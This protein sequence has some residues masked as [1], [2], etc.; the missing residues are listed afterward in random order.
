MSDDPARRPRTISRRDA[1]RATGGVLVF[2]GLFILTGCSEDE[3]Q[4]APPGDRLRTAFAGSPTPVPKTPT[5]QGAAA[6]PN[7]SLYDRLGGHE[8]ISRAV[9][10]FLPLVAL[11]RRINAFFANADANRFV[12]LLT[13][14]IGSLTGGPEKYTGRDMK[15]AHAPM[16]IQK[17]HFDALMEDLQQALTR[18]SVPAKETQELLVILGKFQTDIVTA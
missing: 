15:T 9:Q 6:N 18:L 16:K 13:D 1:L 8:A 17:Q 12:G 14:L 4:A 10:E 2:G 5:P 7:A 11:D 3:V